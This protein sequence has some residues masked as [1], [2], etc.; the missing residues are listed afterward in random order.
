MHALP[1]RCVQCKTLIAKGSRCAA[2][3]PPK[4]NTTSRGYGSAWA[5]L[6]KAVVRRDGYVCA[7][8]GRRATTADH[9]VPKARGGTDDMSNLVAA[10]RS[11]NGRKGVRISDQARR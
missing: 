11:C 6:S 10:C 5:K 2:C 1:R 8:C 9:V 3:T 7:Y 4:A